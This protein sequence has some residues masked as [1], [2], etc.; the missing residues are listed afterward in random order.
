[1]E[2]RLTSLQSIFNPQSRKN[3]LLCDLEFTIESLVDVP[4]VHGQFY[5]SVK[6][7]QCGNDFKTPTP[8][9]V[10]MHLDC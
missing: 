7:N 4:L 6:M 8:L 5:A 1:M 2:R 3:R 9:Y 10:F